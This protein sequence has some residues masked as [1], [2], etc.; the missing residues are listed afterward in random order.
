M[1]CVL[2]SCVVFSCLVLSCLSSLTKG[3]RE[4]ILPSLSLQIRPLTSEMKKYAIMD[5]HYLLYV[6]VVVFALA[7]S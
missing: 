7:L 5:T 1:Y 3:K 4:T 2:L 6:C